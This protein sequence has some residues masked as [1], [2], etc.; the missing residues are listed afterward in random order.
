VRFTSFVQLQSSLA[1]CEEYDGYWTISRLRSA[2]DAA[3]WCF[4]K[5]LPNFRLMKGFG[6][7]DIYLVDTTIL[8][9]NGKS[10][11]ELPLPKEVVTERRAATFLP[12]S[13][14]VDETQRVYSGRPREHV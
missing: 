5:A 7:D 4:S 2:L 14:A 1:I 11:T 3:Q 10:F 12:F 8:H 13:I 9:W 6:A